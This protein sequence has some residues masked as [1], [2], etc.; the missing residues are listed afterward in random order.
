MQK[1]HFILDIIISNKLLLFFSWFYGFIHYLHFS[2]IF[3]KIPKNIP[4]IY[5]DCQA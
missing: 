2:A 1:Y 5:E 4:L 3:C